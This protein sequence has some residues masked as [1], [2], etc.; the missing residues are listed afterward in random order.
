M[1]V[2]GSIVSWTHWPSP[3]KSYRRTWLSIGMRKN[4]QYER[5]VM[6]WDQTFTRSSFKNQS[7]YGFDNLCLISPKRRYIDIFD[8]F[9]RDVSSHWR[10]EYCQEGIN[11]FTLQLNYPRSNRAF[12]VSNEMFSS[13]WVLCTKSCTFFTVY[14]V[15]CYTLVA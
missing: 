14:S 9:N 8:S 7:F 11:R 3:F 13:S 4:R 6:V 5:R 10:V 2:H 1:A 12:E 15:A